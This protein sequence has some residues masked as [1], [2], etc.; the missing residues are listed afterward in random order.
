MLTAV[1][2]G[3]TSWMRLSRLPKP[4]RGADDVMLE[5]GAVDA[6]I[7]RIFAHGDRGDFDVGLLAFLIVVVRPFA[8]RAFVV[9]LFAAARCLR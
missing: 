7:D 5:M 3:T 6:L 8:E 9:A 4:R 2:L 1:V